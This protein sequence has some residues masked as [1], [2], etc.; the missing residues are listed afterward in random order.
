MH[1]TS[2]KVPEQGTYKFEQFRTWKNEFQSTG[3]GHVA[4]IALNFAEVLNTAREKFKSL[5]AYHE[6]LA[7]VDVRHQR[8]LDRLQNTM[9]GAALSYEQS[10]QNQGRSNA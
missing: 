9:T 10:I 2:L 7:N 3:F 8:A 4:Y 1:Q 5:K 6:S